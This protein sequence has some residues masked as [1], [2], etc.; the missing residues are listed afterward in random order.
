MVLLYRMNK[1]K[2]R[3]LNIK[4]MVELRV[5]G[6][7][8]VLPLKIQAYERFLLYLQRIQPAV[9]MNR[10]YEYGIDKNAFH[11]SL[12]KNVREEFEH[13]LAQQ[14]YVSHETWITIC[15]AREQLVSQI[16]A[17]FEKLPDEST[18]TIM[19]S[20]AALPT[21]YIDKA[22]EAVKKEFDKIS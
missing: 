8:L 14:L 3:E 4:G 18:E 6:A 19:Q 10:V 13:N 15:N 12:I 21:P 1:L 5:A 7:K 17:V 16:N 20:L 11:L 22:M 9:L 2:E